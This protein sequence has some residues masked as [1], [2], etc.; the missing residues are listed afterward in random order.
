MKKIMIIGDLHGKTIWK[1]FG[2]IKWLM[3]AE[4]DAAGY[5]PFEPEYDYYIFLGDYTDSFTVD[6]ETI[7]TNLLDLIKFK[8]LYPKNVILLWGNHDVE[9]Y[10]NQPWLPMKTAISG[11]RP[12]MHYDLFEI[13]NRNYDCFQLAFQIDNHLFV[14]GGIHFGWYHYVFMKVIKDMDLGD[15]NI[16]DQLNTA[17]DH[18]IDCLFDV[19]HYRGGYKQVGGPLWVDKKL[20]DNKPLKNMHQYVGHNPVKD[21]DV[22]KID[23]NTTVTFCDFLNNKDAYYVINI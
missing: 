18:R 16:A 14:H 10:L 20:I 9:Y 11:F 4:A 7:R 5:G 1:N 23:N 3:T 21:L 15:L 2:D 12:E 19:D 13:F 22:H 8:N 17:F 6:N